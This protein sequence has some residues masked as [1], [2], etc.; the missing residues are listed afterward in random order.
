MLTLVTNNPQTTR[1]GF[2]GGKRGGARGG[3]RGGAKRGGARGAAKPEVNDKT[4]HLC[5]RL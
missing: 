3:S 2:R 5:K 1:G 4:S